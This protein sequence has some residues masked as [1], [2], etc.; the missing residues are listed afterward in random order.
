MAGYN[1]VGEENRRA[2]ETGDVLD[3][4]LEYVSGNRAWGARE[5]MA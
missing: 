5:A 3:D 2:R 4:A 1:L